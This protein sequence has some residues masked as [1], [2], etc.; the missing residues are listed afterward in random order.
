MNRN[1]AIKEKSVIKTEIT[2]VTNE[3]SGVSRYKGAVVFTPF[4][5]PG[6]SAEVKI[7]KVGKSCVYGKLE[8]VLEPSA[9]RVNPVCPVFGECG[10]CALRHIDYE[11]EVKIKTGWVA[12]HIRRIRQ[13]AWRI[14]PLHG[15]KKSCSSCCLCATEPRKIRRPKM[16]ALTG[17]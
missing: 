2:A 5:A 3:G 17:S 1:D 14:L 12:E 13:A 11:A 7:E 6:D 9:D 16:K 15:R 4:T 8:R 10:G